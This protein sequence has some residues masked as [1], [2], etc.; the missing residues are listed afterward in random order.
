LRK[1]LAY[2]VRSGLLNRNAEEYRAELLQKLNRNKTFSQIVETTDGREIEVTNYRMDEGGW[3]ATH[4]DRTEDRRRDESFRLMFDSNP[5]AMCVFDRE[6]LRFLAVND[7]AI[8][9]YGYSREKFMTMVATDLRAPND[10]TP[11]AFVRGL[12]D[13]E[14]VEHVRHHC[15]AD[16]TEIYVTIFSRTLI[17]DN[18]NAWLVAIND[19][20]VRKLAEDELRRTKMFLNTVI[21]SVPMPIVVKTVKTGRFT[22]VNKA[23][24][25]LHGHRRETI[26]GKTLDDVFSKEVAERISAQDANAWRPVSRSPFAVIRSRR[27]KAIARSSRKRPP[28]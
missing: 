21:E 14:S 17:Y 7:A 4:E 18:K 28:Y 13:S 1:I 5:V 10:T 16:G 22:L 23:S 25:D 2:R 9:Q 11:L 26:I 19:I 15:R 3:V 20:T 24:L 12:S 27:Q 6:T 8:R